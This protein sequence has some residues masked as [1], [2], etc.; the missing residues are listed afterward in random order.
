[1]SITAN[2]AIS[3]LATHKPHAGTGERRNAI[4]FLMPVCLSAAGWLLAS[5]GGALG[6]GMATVLGLGPVLVAILLALLD[7]RNA[8]FSLIVYGFVLQ[9]ALRTLAPGLPYLALQY[10]LPVFVGALL[11]RR[12]VRPRLSIATLAYVIYFVLEVVGLLQSRDLTFA[13]TVLVP[14]ASLFFFLVLYSQTNLQ[15]GTLMAVM[16][17]HVIAGV[18]LAALTIPAY[19]SNIQWITQSNFASSG[20][21]GPDQLAILLSASAYMAY[22]LGTRSTRLMR[23]VYWS[24]ATVLSG[25]MVL[26]FARGGAYILG[27]ALLIHLVLSGRKPSHIITALTVY[28]TG[29]LAVYFAASS[30]TAGAVAERY[31]ELSTSNRSTLAVMGLQMFEANPLIGIGTG[32]YY[33]EVEKDEY[34]GSVSGAHD[35]LVRSAAEHGILGVVCWLWFVVSGTRRAWRTRPAE[36][37][38]FR[39]G[40]FALGVV[41]MM[42][43]GLKLVAQPLWI[44]IALS[45]E[46][47]DAAPRRPPP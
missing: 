1:M 38:A 4:R 29:A 47:V 35:E 21:M 25:V 11:V 15:S 17:A 27:G 44:F 26:T 19:R 10:L 18:S 2:F 23:T 40:L 16:R 42:Y 37:R 9:P 30:I 5:R 24:T 31:S 14:S 8:A 22:V 20:G 34:F 39:S 45:G 32:N 33:S 7:R 43:N 46:V 12:G 36:S 28:A 41:S 3:G 13:R 6:F